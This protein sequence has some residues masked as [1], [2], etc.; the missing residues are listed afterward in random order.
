M[1]Y[2]DDLQRL[3]V[4][5][6]A[7][8]EKLS[9]VR[10]RLSIVR[11]RMTDT[12]NAVK[13]REAEEVSLVSATILPDGKPAYPNVAAREAEVRKRLAAMAAYQDLLADERDAQRAKSLV[14]IELSRTEDEERS[15]ARQFEAVGLALRAEIAQGLERTIREFTVA[16][17]RRFAQ[18]GKS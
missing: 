8:P 13:D 17:A 12:S 2:L 9:A 5:S 15:V 4:S 11:Q 7:F 10:H 1:S 6:D 3:A 14:E 18:E 16:E